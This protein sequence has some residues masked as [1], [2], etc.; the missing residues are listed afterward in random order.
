MA[1]C[2]SHEEL[3]ERGASIMK[4]NNWVSDD[5]ALAMALYM[6]DQSSV[7]QEAQAE[8]WEVIQDHA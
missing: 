2:K 5:D 3:I 7:S 4:H 1:L 6:L 8:I